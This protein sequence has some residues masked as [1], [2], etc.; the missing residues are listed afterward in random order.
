MA[1]CAGYPGSSLCRHLHGSLTSVP[2]TT[3]TAITAFLTGLAPPD[4][5][6]G[7]HMYIPEVAAVGA[8]L[9]LGTRAP[10]R[11]PTA[12]GLIPSRFFDQPSLFDRLPVRSFA[13]SPERIAHWN[14]PDITAAG[15]AAWLVFARAV[16][17]H[18]G[19]SAGGE[20]RRYIMLLRRFRFHFS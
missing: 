10:N 7:W 15:R 20:R 3:A 17:L 4:A 1:T 9:P 18:P 8:V 14:S 2:S 16:R 13:V 12:L 11:P 19:L 5:I 6:T